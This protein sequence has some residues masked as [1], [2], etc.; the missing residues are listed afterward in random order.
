LPVEQ[1]RLNCKVKIYL[2]VCLWMV[3]TMAVPAGGQPIEELT[4]NYIEA[5]KAADQFANQVRV[6][7]SVTAADD[8]PV[9]GLSAADFEILQDGREV[10]V[11]NVSPA[12]DP[13]AVVLAIDT[14]GSMQ[15]KDGSGQTSMTA[16]KKAAVNFI[17][18]LAQDDRVA[19]FS[20]NNEPILKI[21][22]SDD[23]DA[24]IKAVNA[25][26]AKPNAATCLYDTAFEAVKKAAEIP[27][28]RRAIILLTDGKDEKAGLA[29]SMHTAND[30]IGRHHQIYS[31]TD[32]Y[33]RSGPQG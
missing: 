2:M 21:D 30:V 16:A 22:F 10:A 25:L 14:S 19:L 33:Y 20:F 8:N 23:H 9:L 32:I 26:A 15:A 28:G 31:R 27:R 13:M 3:V 5:V 18:M 17:A 11:E 6:Y 7:A 4:I 12:T 29:C 24:S 1:N